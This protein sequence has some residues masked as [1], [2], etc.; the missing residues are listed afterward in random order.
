MHK[1]LAGE[2]PCKLFGTLCSSQVMSVLTSHRQLVEAT[3]KQLPQELQ[4]TT[5]NSLTS[6]QS[7]LETTLLQLSRQ[8]DVH[9]YEQLHVKCCI[10]AGCSIPSQLYQHLLLVARA[11]KDAQREG[12]QGCYALHPPYSDVLPHRHTRQQSRSFTL[13]LP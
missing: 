2:G 4:Q 10:D 11:S 3:G 12:D 8:P 1:L 7:S 6:I 5:I 13:V 9:S